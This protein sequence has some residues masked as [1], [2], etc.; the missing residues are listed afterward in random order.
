MGMDIELLLLPELAHIL[1]QVT[2]RKVGCITRR[3]LSTVL[4]SNSHSTV[5]CK[6]E[7]NR[8]PVRYGLS[9]RTLE[10]R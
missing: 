6:N 7:A 8:R 9:C 3:D 1:D 10:T 2:L 5:S 4:M